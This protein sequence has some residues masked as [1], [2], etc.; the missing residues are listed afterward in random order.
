MRWKDKE[1]RH[2][3]AGMLVE[4]LM[5]LRAVSRVEFF[6][7]TARGDDTV[8]S[9]LDVIVSVDEAT[10]LRWM[11]SVTF[12]DEGCNFY[13]SQKVDRLEAASVCLGTGH[14]L[15]EGW[16]GVLDIFLFP[17]NWKERLNELQEYGRHTDPQFM[18]KIV[19]DAALA[20][21]IH[22]P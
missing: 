6:G 4:D 16:K 3:W 1:T 15:V 7:S 13:G 19:K 8:T 20:V 12:K 5:A 17:E 2:H 10:F 18:H 9:D 21:P 14:W 11:R 22:R